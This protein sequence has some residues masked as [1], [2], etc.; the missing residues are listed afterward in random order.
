MQNVPRSVNLGKI[1]LAASPV[2]SYPTHMTIATS[3]NLGLPRAFLVYIRALGLPPFAKDV[4][5]KSAGTPDVGRIAFVEDV[6]DLIRN[7]EGLVL[8]SRVAWQCV[9]KFTQCG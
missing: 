8:Q 5:R 9:H 4:F 2:F 6:H 7:N 3:D 1:I